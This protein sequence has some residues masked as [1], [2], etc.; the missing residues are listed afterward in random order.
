MKRV[1]TVI[2]AAV[3]ITA[4][5]LAASAQIAGTS[6]KNNLVI[7]QDGKTSASIILAA[8]TGEME[9]LAAADLV[10]YIRPLS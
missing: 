4:H 2:L 6:D 1:T 10:K 9:K 3:T 8:D 7:V 5:A